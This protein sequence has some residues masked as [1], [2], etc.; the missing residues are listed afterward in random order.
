VTADDRTALGPCS[1]CDAPAGE[2]CTWKGVTHVGRRWE[3]G[4]T[5]PGAAFGAQRTLVADGG[6]CRPTIENH[7]LDTHVHRGACLGCGWHGPTRRD[8]NDAV[9]DAHDHAMPG[10]RDLPVVPSPPYDGPRDRWHR[11]VKDIYEAH[12]VTAD[13]LPGTGAPYRT[14]RHGLGTRSHYSSAT[15]GYDISAGPAPA[16]VDYSPQL[17][18]F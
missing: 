8:E 14:Y 9:E 13:W 5:S 3:I 7:D 17:S 2:P 10:W 16:H 6:R 11:S 4:I 12:G 18:L 15:N 1:I